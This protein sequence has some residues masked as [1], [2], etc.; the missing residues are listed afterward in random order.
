VIPI[1]DPLSKSVHISYHFIVESKNFIA[2][3]TFLSVLMLLDW[4][5]CYTVNTFFVFFVLDLYLS[6]DGT[7]V[8]LYMHNLFFVLEMLLCIH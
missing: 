3:L 8:L 4:F 5:D 6:Q 1:C 7:I 2:I